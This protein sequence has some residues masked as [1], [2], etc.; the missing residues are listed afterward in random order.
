MSLRNVL[1]DDFSGGIRGEHG[2]KRGL[3]ECA[4][5]VNCWPQGRNL[6]PMKSH[7][8]MVNTN[9]ADSTDTYTA[10][11]NHQLYIDAD[12]NEYI[13]A[14]RNKSIW[15]GFKST[16]NWGMDSVIDWRP[17]HGDVWSGSSLSLNARGTAGARESFQQV[18]STLY[19]ASEDPTDTDY[20][21]RWDGFVY[22]SGLLKYEGVTATGKGIYG[23]NNPLTDF[24]AL[25]VRVGDILY[26]KNHYTGK[27]NVGTDVTTH[28]FVIDGIDST[29]G[30]GV[31]GSGGS[32]GD[33]ADPGSG[34]PDM[35]GS[36][37]TYPAPAP[38]TSAVV[39]GDHLC[40][41]NPLTLLWTVSITNT[42]IGIIDT[43]GDHLL[44]SYDNAG[45]TRYAVLFSV[46]GVY[47][48]LP[49]TVGVQWNW[50][51]Y[52]AQADAQTYFDLLTAP[53]DTGTPPTYDGVGKL[54]VNTSSATHCFNTTGKGPGATD[55]V[56]YIIV[57]V[58]RAGLPSGTCTAQVDAA[59]G[60]L[61]P[62][63][64]TYRWRYANTKTGYYGTISV[65]SAE[66]T[67]TAGES[68]RMTGWT[69]ALNEPIDR[70]QI[71]RA[72]GT[73][74]YY[75]VK[76]YDRTD[77][78]DWNLF[79][80]WSTYYIDDGWPILATGG[81]GIQLEADSALY[82]RPPVLRSIQLFNG[83]LYAFGYGADAHYLKFS[84]LYNYEA[85]PVTNWEYDTT[86]AGLTVEGGQ[87]P[88]GAN[89]REPLI[90]MVPEGG[91]FTTTGVSGSNLLIFSGSAAYR[92]YGVA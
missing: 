20:L 65:P 75:L 5:M 40:T 30:A 43:D 21:L 17:L 29:G 41:W 90:A 34:T 6:R 56:D 51:T 72:A 70:L 64:Y 88:I 36:S 15:V 74:P 23:H 63:G 47:T 8:R 4:Q 61:T 18:G 53:V 44:V 12:G 25:G 66:I 57:R 54:I 26:L 31:P 86:G 89:R 59:A 73:G 7:D 1:F 42:I 84:T 38:R 71:F 13:T 46:Q 19:M 85:W 67:I 62:G 55:Y 3:T 39:P 77:T 24:E 49:S 48:Q 76:E 79:V 9:D 91:S 78:Y 32:G 14:K 50:Y 58:Q 16:T 33:G 68:V 92:W 22:T 35:F 87:V 82:D 52:A 27:W 45:T 11:Q 80:A 37:A 81:V 2:T 83:R 10:W 28:G 60:T 69:A